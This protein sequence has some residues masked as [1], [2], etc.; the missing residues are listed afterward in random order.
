MPFRELAAA[1]GIG[2]TL[3]IKERDGSAR[4][5]LPFITSHGVAFRPSASPAC[6]RRNIPPLMTFDST[7]ARCGLALRAYRCCRLPHPPAKDSRRRNPPVRCSSVFRSHRRQP[8]G[9]TTMFTTYSFFDV[10]VS[11]DQQ[12][13]GKQ[14]AVDPSAFKD[15]I[16]FVGLRIANTTRISRHHSAAAGTIGVDLH[17]TLADN[18]LS[19]HSCGRS[20]AVTDGALILLAAC[21]RARRR[22][23]PR[24]VGD[25]CGARSVS[26][27]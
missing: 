7:D 18:I 11:G 5:M 22:D 13:E 17:A 2:H 12:A 27:R 19:S 16:V 8:D 3:L 10:L 21:R 20:S 1:A 24:H 26:A 4:R 23:A 15:K 14:P 6:S 25:R 9:G